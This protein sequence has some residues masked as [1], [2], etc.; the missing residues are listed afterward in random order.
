M[1][2][3]N[4]KFEELG[5]SVT[6]TLSRE[7]ATDDILLQH[8]AEMRFVGQRHNIKVAV[9]PTDDAEVLREAFRRDY[10]RRY[11]HADPGA[12]VEVQALHVSAFVRSHKPDLRALALQGQG[13]G[14]SHVRP[15]Y[16]GR[17]HG[18]RETPV[19]DRASLPPGFSGD[20][21]A[22]IDEYG[23]TTLIAPGDRFFIGEL[24]EIRISFLQAGAGAD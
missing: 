8:L 7:F 22:I 3:L 18:W 10:R 6:Q 16:L 24:G 4:A 13:G 15:V 5:A 14:A 9:P 1:P 2:M 17:A 12:L 19:H 20:G 11:G 23:S 21:P